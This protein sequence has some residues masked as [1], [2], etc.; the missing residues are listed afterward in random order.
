MAYLLFFGFIRDYKGLDLLLDA[1]A[2]DRIRQMKVEAAGGW[3]VLWRPAEIFWPGEAAEPAEHHLEQRLHTQQQGGGLLRCQQ[4]GGAAY[5]S[6][7]QSGVT[8]VAFHFEKP[9]LVTNVGGLSEIVPDGK[10]GY[11]VEPD[12][13]R[14][15]DAI[16]D[17]IGNNREEAFTEQTRQ[18][19]LKYSWRTWPR[20]PLSLAK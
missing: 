15:A 9:M 6:A 8:Q 1:F 18:E 12:A 10:V 7:T 5:K 14:I 20:P 17:Y 2:D 3:R 4:H 19:K 11:V 13:H 16:V